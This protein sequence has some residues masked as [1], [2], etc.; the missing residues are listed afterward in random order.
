MPP[1]GSWPINPRKFWLLYKD[2]ALSFIPSLGKFAEIY[3]LGLHYYCGPLIAM[4]FCLILRNLR[5]N[6]KQLK[7]SL[8]NCIPNKG[9]D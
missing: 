7:L 1:A 9:T 2:Y 6:P 4:F 3:K 5:S 8:E